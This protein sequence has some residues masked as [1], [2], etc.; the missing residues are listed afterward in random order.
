MYAFGIGIFSLQFIC[1][2]AAQQELKC[3]G[4]ICIYIV[5]LHVF[6][7]SSLDEIE[8]ELEMPDKH[9]GESDN[10]DIKCTATSS[11]SALNIPCLSL[12]LPQCDALRRD[13]LTTPTLLQRNK[14]WRY[15]F[16]T[17]SSRG[18][19]EVN[20]R[21]TRGEHKKIYNQIRVNIYSDYF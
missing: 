11:N 21:S 14:W 2:L 16:F 19:H 7:E 6:A 10:G 8:N 12:P 4:Y 1:N 20:T 18:R 5:F 9:P 3:S 13:P 15:L 17:N